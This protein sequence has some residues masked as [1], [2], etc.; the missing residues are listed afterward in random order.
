MRF[1]S[2]LPVK[3]PAIYGGKPIFSSIIPIVQPTLPSLE[4]IKENIN[5]IL[6]TGLIT[7]NKYVQEFEKRMSKYLEEYI[8]PIEIYYILREKNIEIPEKMMFAEIE[9]EYFHEKVLRALIYSRGDVTE[10]FLIGLWDKTDVCEVCGDKMEDNCQYP[11]G[12]HLDHIKPI[13][14][15]GLHI[16][17]NVRYIHAICNLRKNNKYN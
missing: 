4:D 12:R 17:K 6:T 14:L 5:E 7:N 3:K 15:G 13:S 8:H 2:N 9:Y 10:D 16:K 11:H 1:D